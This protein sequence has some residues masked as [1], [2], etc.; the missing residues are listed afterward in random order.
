MY[1]YIYT[2]LY[3]ICPSM[4]KRIPLPCVPCACLMS[5]CVRMLC[6]LG[7]CARARVH[8][9]PPTH[10]HTHTHTRTHTHTHQRRTDTGERVPGIR[11]KP[12]SG[13]ICAQVPFC[14]GV[15]QHTAAGR[16]AHCCQSHRGKVCL[17]VSLSMCVR[18]HMHAYAYTH[19][20]H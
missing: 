10:T 6:V 4:T 18:V 9:H 17:C 2:H 8:T 14:D 16:R 20:W 3:I 19:T 5:V 15:F 11:D 12:E 13:R 7:A 1:D